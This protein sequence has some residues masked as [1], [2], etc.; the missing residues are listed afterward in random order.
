[1]TER[2]DRIARAWIRLQRDWWAFDEV[3]RACSEQP[4]KAWRLLGRL[5]QLASSQELVEVLGA[6]P[7]Q[8]F[9]RSHAP[10]FIRQIER[11]AAQNRRFASALRVVWLPHGSDDIS[12][13]LFAL[14]CRPINT[15]REPWQ[16]G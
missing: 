4:R 2:D 11:R 14:G 8:D 13:R 6:G 12:R 16:T 1:M 3:A 9:V 10:A 7:L 15:T 5:A